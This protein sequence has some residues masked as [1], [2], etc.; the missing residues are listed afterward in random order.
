MRLLI[1][2]TREFAIPCFVSLTQ[3]NHEI[4]GVVAV[5]DARHL[6]RAANSVCSVARQFGVPCL[7]LNDLHS[8]ASV[9]RLKAL[10]ADL[11]IVIGF[12]LYLPAQLREVFDLGCIGVHASLLPKHRGRMPIMR[13]FL[14]GDKKTGVSVFRLTDQID[15]GPILVQRETMIGRGETWADLHFR[16]SRMACDALNASLAMI[17]EGKFHEQRHSLARISSNLGCTT[18]GLGLDL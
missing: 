4:T 18:Q 8:S 14:S 6:T 15:S 3:G 11:G 5:R 7:Y 1:F 9:D 12:G 2:G 13:A 16:L 17:T 10:R